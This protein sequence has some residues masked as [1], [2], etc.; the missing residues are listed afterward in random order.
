MPTSSWIVPYK[1]LAL[2]TIY[3]SQYRIKDDRVWRGCSGCQE[4]CQKEWKQLKQL[5]EQDSAQKKPQKEQACFSLGFG[6][7][8][9]LK[10]PQPLRWQRAEGGRFVCVRSNRQYLALLNRR[11][12]LRS[13]LWSWAREAGVSSINQLSQNDSYGQVHGSSV[14]NQ[15]KLVSFFHPDLTSALRCQF[16]WARIQSAKVTKV[17]LRQEQID[18]SGI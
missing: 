7:I 14:F 3:G 11:Q 8:F 12:Y 15:A 4:C 5:V 1:W 2:A 17:R 18:L 9:A 13:T 16:L 10:K 6:L